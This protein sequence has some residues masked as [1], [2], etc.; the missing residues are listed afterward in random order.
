M[1]HT[2]IPKIYKIIRIEIFRKLILKCIFIK[3]GGVMKAQAFSKTLRAIYRNV[4]KIEIGYGCYGP[5]CFNFKNVPPNTVFGN[6]SSIAL[7]LLIFRANHPLNVFTTHPILY[8][9][10][11][12]YVKDYKLEKKPLI[13]GHDVWIGREV[14]ILP[15]VNTIGNGAIIGAG[16]VVTKDVEPYSIVAGNPAKF[17]RKRFSDK[18]IKKLED[19]EWW[20]LEYTD[21]TKKIDTFN[22]L[23]NED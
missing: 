3:N 19:S 14:I 17:I 20:K 10:L 12:G 8:N 13:V 15:N 22:N 1:G 18:V 6:Y 11:M 9:P 21:L 5:G 7:N 4:Y 2:I 16:S 23:V